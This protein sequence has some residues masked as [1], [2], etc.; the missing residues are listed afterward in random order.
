M[1]EE[2]LR[3]LGLALDEWSGSATAGGL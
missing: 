2:G 3:R 1:L